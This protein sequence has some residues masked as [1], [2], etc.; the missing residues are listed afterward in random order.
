MPLKIWYQFIF[1]DLSKLN[2]GSDLDDLLNEIKNF[3]NKDA[4]GFQKLL[5]QSEKI[6]N[7][8]F[9]KLA[10]KPFHQLIFM[11]KQIPSLIKL[12]SY[13]SVYDLVSTYIKDEKLRKAFTI[14]PLLVGGNPYTTTSIYALILFLERKWGVHYSLEALVLWLAL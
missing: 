4:S 10:E 3:N 7:I 11:L 1:D 12:K 8:G 13:Q 6:F 14:H 9:T 5:K 2:Y